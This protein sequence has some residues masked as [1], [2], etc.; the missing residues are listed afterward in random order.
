MAVDIMTKGLAKKRH[1]KLVELIGLEKS[2]PTTTPSPVED[3]CLIRKVDPEAGKFDEL[4]CPNTGITSGS[5]ELR[6]SPATTLRRMELGIPGT[7]NNGDEM[8]HVGPKDSPKKRRFRSLK[9]ETIERQIGRCFAIS[10]HSGL[11]EFGYP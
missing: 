2:R 1:E 7:I 8:K 6:T 10:S 11:F 9:R 4:K 3:D 5:V